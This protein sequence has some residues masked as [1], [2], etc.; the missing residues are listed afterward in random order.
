MGREL[1]RSTDAERTR[2]IDELVNLM[3][4]RRTLLRRI[5]QDARN[6]AWLQLWL[7]VHVPV[8]FALLGALVAHVVSVFLYW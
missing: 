4:A 1:A 8:T 3:S 5:V 2:R 6:V 7:Y